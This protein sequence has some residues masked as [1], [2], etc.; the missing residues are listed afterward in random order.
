MKYRESRTAS[1]VSGYLNLRG[2][3][4]IKIFAKFCRKVGKQ[5]V[6]LVMLEDHV[7]WISVLEQ[8]PGENNVILKSFHNYVNGNVDNSL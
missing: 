5:K 6:K 3:K 7:M 4:Q 8:Q 2:H 1:E